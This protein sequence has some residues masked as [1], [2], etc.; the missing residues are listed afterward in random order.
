MTGRA[1]TRHLREDRG[2]NIALVPEFA[3]WFA[4]FHNVQHSTFLSTYFLYGVKLWK[5]EYLMSST[6]PTMNSPRQ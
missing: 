6:L 4:F 2:V 1:E 5:Q 3:R